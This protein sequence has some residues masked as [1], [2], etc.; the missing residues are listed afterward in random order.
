MGKR[1]TLVRKICGRPPEADFDEVRQ[2]LELEGYQRREGK[3][4]HHVF[5]KVG[6]YPISIPT[7]GGRKVKRYYLDNICE[8]LELDEERTK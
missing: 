2:L 5:V 6:A 8:L 4:S 3:G 7:K 1:E